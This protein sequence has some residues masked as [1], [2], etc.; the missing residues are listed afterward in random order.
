MARRPRVDIAKRRRVVADMYL[1]GTV[2]SEIAD[3]LA[4]NQSTISRDLKALQKAWLESALVDLDEA[5]ARELAKVDNLEREYWTAW[6]RSC[7]DAETV[8]QK[9][10][11]G[12]EGIKTES[13]EKTSKGQ[14]GDPRFLAGVQ[15]CI[16]RRCKI[17]GIDAPTRSELTGKGGG[18]IQT[19]GVGIEQRERDRAITALANTLTNHVYRGGDSEYC[20]V[21]TTE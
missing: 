18:P 20:A 11:P 12:A 8:R 13:I 3:E 16:E 1:S 5:K 4:V 2:Q 10:A 9:G 6:E 19:E 7:E 14:A 15:W 21:D 17:I